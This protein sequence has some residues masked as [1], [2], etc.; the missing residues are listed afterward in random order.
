MIF[1]PLISI[2]ATHKKSLSNILPC[3]TEK[4]HFVVNNGYNR[5]NRHHM[6]KLIAIPFYVVG[7]YDNFTEI[8]V[9]QICVLVVKMGAKIRLKT[10]LC[11]VYFYFVTFDSKGTV[12]SGITSTLSGPSNTTLN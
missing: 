1:I 6:I 8:I 7:R 9:Q 11:L 2:Q 4:S 5:C 3:G 10:S 12:L